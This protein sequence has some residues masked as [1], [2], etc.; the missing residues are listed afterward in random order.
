MKMMIKSRRIVPFGAYLT[1][2]GASYVSPI[3]TF[4]VMAATQDLTLQ[5]FLYQ[6]LSRLIYTHTAL[7]STFCS[8]M[9]L[10]EL[11]ITFLSEF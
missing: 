10:N 2:F 1:H 8:S 5:T 3:A 7:A 6:D 4:L 11:D 9:C